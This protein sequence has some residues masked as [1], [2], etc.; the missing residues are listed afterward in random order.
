MKPLVSV[1]IIMYEHEKYINE[2]INSIISQT[3]DNL[4]I[5]VVDDG[6]TD[7]GLLIVEKAH[8]PR[9][10]TIR[11]K[12]Q[13]PSSALNS[14]LR[15]A[16]GEFIALFSGDDIAALDHIEHQLE[17]IEG[18]ESDLVFGLPQLIDEQGRSLLDE[19]FPAFFVENIHTYKTHH[20][21]NRF[22]Y[23]GNFLCAPS[24]FM[25]KA[26]FESVGYFKRG[27]IQLQDFDYWIRACKHSVQIR[28]ADHRT[29]FYRIRD[30]DMNLSSS[31]NWQRSDLENEYIMRRFFNE[32][33]PELIGTAFKDDIL[34]WDNS[35]DFKEE[36]NQ[37]MIYLNHPNR[38]FR[39][40][41][42]EQL[43]ELMDI[44]TARQI[45]VEKYGI[46]LDFFFQITSE[47]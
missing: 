36:I 21:F 17:F 35:F 30:N 15:A 43:I 4:E 23:S 10:I 19:I 45:L 39:Q 24:A 42:Y 28:I 20:I 11:Q 32:C 25:K 3:Y 2:S 9:I 40:Y 22:F 16:K 34:F 12:N 33:N 37:S 6:S 38:V 5:I 7:N 44:K 29:I 31:N 46:P 26:V 47:P 1:I 14:G 8:D 27:L 41:G 13:G 18:T